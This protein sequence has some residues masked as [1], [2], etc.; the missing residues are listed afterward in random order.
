MSTDATLIERACQVMH[1]AYEAAAIR[2]GWET[3]ER[4]RVAWADVPEAN[5]A[6]MRAAVSALLN[7][8]GT[9]KPIQELTHSEKQA[10]IALDRGYSVEIA[11]LCTGLHW[12]HVENLARTRRHRE[13]R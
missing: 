2:E 4:S 3:Q 10:L 6:T 1:D 12:E 5:Q 9:E 13:Y 7:Y 8:L 11:A